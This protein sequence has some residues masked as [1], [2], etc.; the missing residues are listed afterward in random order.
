MNQKVQLL[1]KHVTE[2]EMQGRLTTSLAYDKEFGNW[3]WSFLEE[4]LANHT[5]AAAR[6]EPIPV[7][8]SALNVLHV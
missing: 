6:V 7:K 5:P 4:T 1:P 8:V 2:V 3:V